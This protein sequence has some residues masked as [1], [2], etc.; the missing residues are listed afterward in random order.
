MHYP[1]LTVIL[2]ILERNRE[3]MILFGEFE[4][5][6]ND[7]WQINAKNIIHSGEFEF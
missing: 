6:A 1:L 5:C 7:V 2:P 4:V 3:E